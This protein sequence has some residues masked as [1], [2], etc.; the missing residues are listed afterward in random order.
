MQRPADS[1][2]SHRVALVNVFFGPAP[3]WMPAF[4]LTCARNPQ[5]DWLIFGDMPEPDGCPPNVHVLPL[6]LNEF[7][8]RASVGLGLDV[9]IQQGFI[10][11]ICDLKPAYGEI[12]ADELS[13]YDFWGH[14]DVDV[15]WGKWDRFITDRL[16]RRFDIISGRPNKVAGHLTLYRNA[17]EISSVYRSI[18]DV[19]RLI[20]SPER[21][22]VDERLIT[23]A[24]KK[25]LTRTPVL[26][27]RASATRPNGVRPRVYWRRH[28]TTKGAHQQ[29]V[30][31]DNGRCFWWRDGRTYDA[32]GHERLY[33]HFHR[34]KQTMATINFDHRDPPSA[35]RITP[36]GLF[37]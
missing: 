17:P 20:A 22:S 5:V 12:F 25:E 34:I 35:F 16:L 3:F 36:E 28:L 18:P 27:R 11:K 21:H 26:L 37:T 19:D 32:D 23:R 14:C 29:T 31:V 15:V 6:S 24:V 1:R 33:I 9:R 10:Y 8:E 2:G 13:P 7:N 4:L 30:T